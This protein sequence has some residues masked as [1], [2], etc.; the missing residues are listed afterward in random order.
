MQRCLDL[1]ILGLGNVAPNPMVG[2]VIVHDGKVI[3]EGYHQRIGEA[4]A[5]VNAIKSVAN[6]E[7]LK[8]STLY[9][10][11]EPCSHHGK[12]PP[13]ADL[14]LQMKIPRVV[15]GSYDPNLLVSGKGIQKLK[16][17]GVEVV[18]DVMKKEADFMNRR[19]ITFH[20]KH[21][22]YIILKWAQ[23]ADGLIALNEQKQ[24]WLTN[25][26]SKKLTHKWRTEEQG[27]LVGANTVAVDDCELTARLWQG[28]NPMRAVIDRKLVLPA[29][30]KIFN[31][32]AVTLIF[33]EMKTGERGSNRY[34]WIDFN[35]NVVGQILQKL[36]ELQIQSLIVE[37][38]PYTLNR[39]LEQ[40]LWDEARI[41]VTA[42]QLKEGK[43][44]PVIKQSY[45]DEL[46]IEKDVLRTYFNTSA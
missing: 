41:F 43:T 20:T 2:C 3:G 29:D 42:Q 39:F 25:S 18:T 14:I 28:K 33:N 24:Y 30:R 22:P 1:A 6:Q 26:E 5:E 11:L 17:A 8:D 38:G 27:I 13:C 46:E 4:H 35:G 31:G 40:G 19:F 9:V 32:E 7:L 12:T 21:R 10:N 36:Y 45:T 34:I 16:E 37:G 44:A 15:I 23:S